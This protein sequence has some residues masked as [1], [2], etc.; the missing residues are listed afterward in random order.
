MVFASNRIVEKK[1][2]APSVKMFVVEAPRI[3]RKGKAGQFVVVRIGEKGERIP[4]TI[5]D[6]DAERGVITLIVQEV[7]KTTARLGA[8]RQGERLLDLVGPLGIPSQ[9][10]RFGKVVLVGGGIGVAPLFPIVRAMK[11]AGN[12]VIS[13]IGARNKELLFWEEK[14]REFSDEVAVTT[15]DGSFGHKGFVTDALREVISREPHVDLVMA[16][17][18]VVMMKAVAEVTR[19]PG[20]RTIVSLNPIMVDATGMCGGC[21]VTVGGKLKFACVEGPEFDGHLVD[22]D[23]LMRRQRTYLE[24][25]KAA[26]EAMGGK[27][28]RRGE[29]AVLGNGVD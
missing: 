12:F 2:L 13:I 6:S 7:G 25:E 3:A 4:L 27:T 17:G 19:E 24:E 20:I 29:T 23:E 11:N 26:V 16:I 10:E 22:F 9:I 8:L 21:R 28:P 18:P 5:A 14:I 15:D 1:V